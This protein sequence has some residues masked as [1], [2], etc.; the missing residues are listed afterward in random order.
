[1]TVSKAFLPIKSHRYG[2]ISTRIRFC[3]DLRRACR[4]VVEIVVG[5]SLLELV[6]EIEGK[7]NLGRSRRSDGIDAESPEGIR[8]AEVKATARRGASVTTLDVC[9]SV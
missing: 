4:T 1:M 2:L 3:R 8:K 5:R 9:A 6:L 7:R